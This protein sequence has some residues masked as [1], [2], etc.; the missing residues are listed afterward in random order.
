MPSPDPIHIINAR[1]ICD[2]LSPKLH[3]A[4]GLLAKGDPNRIRPELHN[5]VEQ[6]LTDLEALVEAIDQAVQR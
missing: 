6:L 1:E 2:G 4:R 5:R 3:K